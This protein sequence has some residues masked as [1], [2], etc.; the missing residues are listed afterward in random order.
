MKR[1]YNAIYADNKHIY[2]VANNR[3]DIYD[4]NNVRRR[5][6]SINISNPS[7]IVSDCEV[8]V[9][10]IV[11]TESKVSLYNFKLK[12]IV[13]FKLLG[14]SFIYLYDKDNKKLITSTIDLEKEKSDIYV[15]NL[16]NK[17]LFTKELEGLYSYSPYK[18]NDDKLILIKMMIGDVN[19]ISIVYLDYKTLE[20]L[21]LTETQFEGGTFK[22]IDSLWSF[23]Y[24]NGLYNFDHGKFISYKQLNVNYHFVNNVK[25]YNNNYYI[26]TNENILIYNEEFTQIRTIDNKEYDNRIV[27]FYLDSKTEIILRNNKTEVNFGDSRFL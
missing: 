20:I 4:K 19:T 9:I 27:D 10:A 13:D 11:N 25:K 6:K 16:V 18:A 15:I 7:Y 17:K 14:E 5:I 2:L 12:H 21:S 23:D 3:V 8:D 26:I 1:T 24:N 22:L